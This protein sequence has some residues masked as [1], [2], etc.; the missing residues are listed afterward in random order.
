MIGDPPV[1][2]GC[3]HFHQDSGMP[4]RCNAFPGEEGIPDAIFVGGNPHNRPFPGDN[5]LRFEP[6]EPKSNRK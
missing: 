4:Y 2:L 5:G 1:C 3:K 6:I